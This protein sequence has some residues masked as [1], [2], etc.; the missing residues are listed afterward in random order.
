VIPNLVTCIQRSV[1]HDGDEDMRMHAFE[2]FDTYVA[3]L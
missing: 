3:Q 2:V 1:G